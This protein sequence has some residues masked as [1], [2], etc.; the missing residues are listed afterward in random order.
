[1][2]TLDAEAL[3]FRLE[4]LELAERL[5]EDARMLVRRA[6]S[7]PW[8]QIRRRRQFARLAVGVC[9]SAEAWLKIARG[10]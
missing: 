6:N 9:D 7:F 8:W 2:N 4:A 3:A 10:E 5:S 1:M